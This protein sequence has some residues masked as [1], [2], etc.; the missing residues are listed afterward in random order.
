MVTFAAGESRQYL[1]LSVADDTVVENADKTLFLTIV[2][3]N[4]ADCPN[5]NRGDPYLLAVTLQDN[6][7]K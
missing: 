7:G 2:D 4:G 1:T 3:P 6:D 5:G